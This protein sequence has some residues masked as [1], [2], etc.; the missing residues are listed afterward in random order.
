M[1]CQGGSAKS[2]DALTLMWLN[3]YFVNIWTTN[4]GFARR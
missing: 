2:M 3:G 4:M 1:K